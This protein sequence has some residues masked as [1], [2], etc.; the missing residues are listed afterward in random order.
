M[1][2]I[3]GSPSLLWPL[4]CPICTSKIREDIEK[5]TENFFQRTIPE[6]PPPQQ[7]GKQIKNKQKP[8]HF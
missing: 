6:R 4:D 2:G 3:A 7:G 8:T 1:A 5:G